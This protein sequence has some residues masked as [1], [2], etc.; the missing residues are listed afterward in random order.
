MGGYV[1]EATLRQMSGCEISN[2]EV[3]G[4]EVSNEVME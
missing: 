4:T 2:L 1:F 3:F